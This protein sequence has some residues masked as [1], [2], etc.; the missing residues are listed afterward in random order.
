[1]SVH[2]VALAAFVRIPVNVITESGKVITKS[3]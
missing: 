2:Q 1:M 3:W